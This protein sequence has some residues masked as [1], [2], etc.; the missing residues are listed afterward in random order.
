[1]TTVEASP[2]GSVVDDVPPL[3]ESPPGPSAGEPEP[4]GSKVTGTPPKKK[5]A[6]GAASSP[7]PP[8][9]KRGPGRPR[10]AKTGQR[11]LAPELHALIGQVGMVVY[12]VHQGDG[13]AVLA[14][15]EGLAKALDNLARRNPSV[16]RTLDKVLTAGV[17]GELATAVAAIAIPIAANHGL[18]PESIALMA[19]APAAQTDAP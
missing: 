14:G 4:A 9:P 19:Q 1:M 16:Y 10:G 18:L 6:T 12:V 15:A 11:N 13:E 17:Y 7:A 5:K 2:V 8:L 3:F